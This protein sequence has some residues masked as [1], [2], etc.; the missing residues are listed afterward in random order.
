MQSFK[1]SKGAISVNDIEQVIKDGQIIKNYSN[2]KP[3]PSYL[4]KGF[5][6]NKVLHVVVSYDILGNYYIITA[7]QPDE[8]IWNVDF[9][10][11]K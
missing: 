5:V 11:K 9:T 3:F 8:G 2:D 1:C 6:D 10:I 4:V 7:Y